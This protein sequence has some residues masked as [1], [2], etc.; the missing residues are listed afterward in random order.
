MSSTL[1]P[2][3]DQ[4]VQQALKLVA[5]PLTLKT[6]S[7]RPYS[8]HRRQEAKNQQ[9]CQEAEGERVRFS[10]PWTVT[11]VTTVLS[12]FKLHDT[13]FCLINIKRE[14][15]LGPSAWPCCKT[16]PHSTGPAEETQR[17][18]A[19]RGRGPAGPQP[20]RRPRGSTET[21]DSSSFVFAFISRPKDTL[22]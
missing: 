21:L 5:I 10:A 13:F 11:S 7:G 19:S 12:G 20:S 17:E 2:S 9:H 14:A 8:W 16:K 18:G 1:L 4:T 6:T 3:G 22:P 15:L